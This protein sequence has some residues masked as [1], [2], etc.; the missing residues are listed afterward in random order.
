MKGKLVIAVTL[1][2]LLPAAALADQPN[3]RRDKALY[4]YV[5]TLAAAP[6][7]SSLTLNVENGN[8]AALRS[9]L[10]Q[11]DQQTFSFDSSTEFLKWSNGVPTVVSPSALGSGDWVRVNIRA[12][13]D[14]TLATIESTRPGIVGDHGTE[15]QAPD[16]PLFLFRGTLTAVGSSTVTAEVAG[17][18]RRALRLMIGQ[19]AQQSFAF[20]SGTI[21][22]LWQGRVPTVISPGQLKVGDRFVVR[23]RADRG[24]TL[25]QVEATP[26]AHLGDREPPAAPAS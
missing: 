13:R 19:P 4:A 10:G 17:G 11:S 6:G 23:V 7:S 1:V 5:G 14:A 16:K 15:P 8:R 9:L 24:S 20:D 26:A 21:V 18:N 22:L 2:G 3:G 25:A 12:P